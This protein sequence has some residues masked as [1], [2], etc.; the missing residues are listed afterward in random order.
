[1]EQKKRM[2]IGILILA[3]LIAIFFIVT[4]QLS[5]SNNPSGFSVLDGSNESKFVECLKTKELKL[6][7]NSQDTDEALKNTGLVDYLQYF[8]MQNCF[9]NNLPC[10]DGEITNFPTWVIDNK[11][12]SGDI[13]YSELAEYSGC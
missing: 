9:I 11:K 7:I 5:N 8:E 2:F 10:L 13:S 6:Y 12:I 3:L 1:M 4:N